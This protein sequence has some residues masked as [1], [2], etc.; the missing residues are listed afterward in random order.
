MK[1]WRIFESDD[2]SCMTDSDGMIVA[3]QLLGN[4][5]RNLEPVTLPAA[6]SVRLGFG[7][8]E[9]R[10]LQNRQ[11]SHTLTFVLSRTKAVWRRST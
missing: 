11:C 3:R 7:Y 10:H 4:S 5:G 9:A 8:I 1:T 6:E 2:A